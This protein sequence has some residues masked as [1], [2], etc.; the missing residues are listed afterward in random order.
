MEPDRPLGS[1]SGTRGVPDEPASLPHIDHTQ[2]GGPNRIRRYLSADEQVR[3]LNREA[4]YCF[5]ILT[6]DGE[7]PDRRSN[8][9]RAP[10]HRDEAT[11]R[12]PKTDHFEFM[13]PYRLKYHIR[14]NVR[15]SYDC[16]TKSYV[17]DGSSSKRDELN[18]LLESWGS[19]PEYV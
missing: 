3:Y 15:N 1:Y 14:F 7:A 4:N 18:E 2:Q 13:C 11:T 8:R 6:K 17:C 9:K 16:A 12:H 10:V 5:R 19:I